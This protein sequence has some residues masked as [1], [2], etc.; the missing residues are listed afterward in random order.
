MKSKVRSLK[1]GFVFQDFRLIEYMSVYDN[2]VLGTIFVKIS[3]S[4]DIDYLLEQF[5]LTDVK[6]LKCEVL[7]GGQKQRVC[8]IRALLNNPDLIILDEPTGNLDNNNAKIIEEYLVKLS[9]LKTTLLLVTHDQEL[10]AIANK[11]Y[12]LKTGKLYEKN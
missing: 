12:E 11:C 5:D 3:T 6:N 7:S 8:L 2:I 9:K 1:V 10:A 4:V